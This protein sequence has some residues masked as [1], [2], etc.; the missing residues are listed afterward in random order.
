MSVDRLA[1]I[2]VFAR[3]VELGSFTR[4]ADALDVSKAV[5]SKYVSRLERR[6]GARLLQRTTRR[7]T[8]TEPGAALYRRSAGAL[9]EL[10]EAENDVAQLTGAPRGVLHHQGKEPGEDQIAREG[11]AEKQQGGRVLRMPDRDRLPPAGH[12]ARVKRVGV[13]GSGVG[14]EVEQQRTAQ[15]AV[16][17]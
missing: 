11:V 16:I 8:L 14:R 12:R 2:A 5:V 3:V 10:A 7:L 13:P 17:A 1:D 15:R 6:L 4:A 9:A